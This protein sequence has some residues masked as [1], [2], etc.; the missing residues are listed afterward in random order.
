MAFVC[1][2]CAYTAADEEDLQDHLRGEHPWHFVP[3]QPISI[4]TPPSVVAAMPGKQKRVL[5]EPSEVIGGSSGSK[6]PPADDISSRRCKGCDGPMPPPLP[7]NTRVVEPLRPPIPSKSAPS[8]PIALKVSAFINSGNS[9]IR[10]APQS[11]QRLWV[12]MGVES[13][14]DVANM[15]TDPFDMERQLVSELP[16]LGTAGLSMAA[17]AVQK[18]RHDSALEMAMRT[19]AIQATWDEPP[20]QRQAPG[21][22]HAG[23]SLKKAK[24]MPMPPKAVQQSTRQQWDQ[25]PALQ[26]IVPEATLTVLKEIYSVYLGV[27]KLGSLWE[28]VPKE[29]EAAREDLFCR[30]FVH[31]DFSRLKALLSGLRRWAKHAA[32]DDRLSAAEL[33]T[34]SVVRLGRFLSKISLG[35]PTAAAAM[36]QQ[37]LWWRT[38]VGIQ[39]PLDSALVTP[40]RLHDTTHIVRQAE[41]LQPWEF[42]NLVVMCIRSTGAVQKVLQITLLIAVSCLRWAHAQRSVILGWFEGFIHGKCSKGKR[43]VNGV[44]APFEWFTPRVKYVDRDIF[45]S[46]PEFYQHW[47]A[48]SGS[49]LTGLMPDIQLIEGRLEPHSRF[50]TANMSY[51]KFTDILQGFLVAIGNDPAEAAKRSTYLLR[52]FLPTGADVLDFDDT[53][54]AAVGNWQES[55]KGERGRSRESAK[56]T[57]ARRYAGDAARSCLR[58]K[59]VIVR[60]LLKALHIMRNKVG[61][62]KILMPPKESIAGY[63]FQ[64]LLRPG[65]FMWPQLREYVAELNVPLMLQNWGKGLNFSQLALPG[66]SGTDTVAQSVA[67]DLSAE[68]LPDAGEQGQPQLPEAAS[69]SSNDSDSS[70]SDT[71]ES[72]EDGSDVWADDEFPVLCQW[73]VQGKSKMAHIVRAQDECGRNVPYCREVCFAHPATEQGHGIVTAVC[74]ASAICSK[75]LR[76]MPEKF[77][78]AIAKAVKK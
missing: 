20:Q 40:F 46:L 37:L 28:D 62:S 54:A 52:R 19:Q 73:F 35:G 24:K 33:W 23:L 38:Y 39:F 75:C 72:D 36:F 77:S 5:S 31:F 42:F 11:V 9:W 15:Y 26:S 32:E 50:G 12:G 76:R 61:D 51:R 48:R 27:G 67:K 78:V 60:A 25:Q 65:V 34:P 18:A 59:F 22:A 64:G 44:Q 58:P 41:E 8:D 71:T 53:N 1:S 47:E 30:R 69:D 66:P 3:A 45:S 13:A 4:K 43:R 55:V 63:E 21:V 56:Q 7:P 16:D 14:C 57:M 70:S 2:H 10:I 49:P 74:V 68:D 6:D 29:E 17:A